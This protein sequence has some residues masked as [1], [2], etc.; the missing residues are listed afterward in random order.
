MVFRM[1]RP[2][3][4]KGSSVIQ[5]R[6]RIPLDLREKAR[7]TTFVVPV[8][9]T[10]AV[11]TLTARSKEVHFSL[12]TRDPSE[13]KQRHG[14][15]TAYVE[16]VWKSLR[17]GAV[18][19]SQKQIVALSGEV[20]ARL[21]AASEDNPGPAEFWDWILKLQTKPVGSGLRIPMSGEASTA[22]A[23]A[24]VWETVDRAL[25]RHGIVATEDSRK[26]LL[27]ELR[28]VHHEAAQRGRQLAGGDYRRDTNLERFPAFQKP[29]AKA[30]PEGAVSLTGLV[31]G[32]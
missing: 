13:A 17:E 1:A 2:V 28:Q 5:F 24:N 7:G 8:G 30:K 11:V 12:L 14:V 18:T 22:T 31:E 16:G 10:E 23:P 15:A 19:L 9:D 20:Y 21:T 6:Q 4:R 26:R 32:W 25:A 29:E 27:F 3:R